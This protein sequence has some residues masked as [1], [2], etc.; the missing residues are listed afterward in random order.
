MVSFQIEQLQRLVTSQEPGRADAIVWLLGNM[1]DRGKK[2]V[3]LYQTGYAPLIVITGNNERIVEDDRVHVKDVVVWLLDRGIKKSA[4]L[5]DDQ[6]IN[7][8][9]QAKHVLAIA[10]ERLWKKIILVGSAY[11]Q[12]RAFLTFLYQAKKIGWQGRIINQPA[13]ID[14]DARPGGR[15]KTAQELFQ[16]EIEKL[17][18][19]KENVATAEEGIEYFKKKQ[20]ARK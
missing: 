3:E 18:E 7:T 2:V 5:A 12:L 11:H 15:S 14:W 13:Y 9:D 10:Q 6:S 17:D 8:L 16:E 19:Y 4:I 1:Y 20:Y